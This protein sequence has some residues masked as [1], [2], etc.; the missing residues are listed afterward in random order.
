M[1][2]KIHTKYL[3]VAISQQWDE[4]DWFFKMWFLFYSTF[5]NSAFMY[6]EKKVF[7]F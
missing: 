3:T 6:N 2:E 7:V 5:R 1:A 4:D